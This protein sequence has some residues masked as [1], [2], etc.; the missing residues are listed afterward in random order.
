[1]RNRH[2]IPRPATMLEMREVSGAKSSPRVRPV[3][4]MMRANCV[5]GLTWVSTF[6]RVSESTTPTR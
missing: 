2:G 3:V 6:G 5:Q 4:F 1:M